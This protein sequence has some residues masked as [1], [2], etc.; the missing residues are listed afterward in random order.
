MGLF[1]AI[2]KLTGN[3]APGLAKASAGA[4]EV[5]LDSLDISTAEGLLIL[6]VPAS[7]V[8]VLKQAA[9]ENSALVL[10]GPA[11]ASRST[12][13]GAPVL[14]AHLTP[15]KSD[16]LPV[17]DQNRGWLVPLTPELRDAIAT[18]LRDEPDGYELTE[19]VAIVV[20]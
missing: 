19:R 2:K 1:D 14:A 3:G 11:D 20:E 16:A 6:T 9:A 7:A 10:R 5:V 17:V 4:P 18:T 15:T 8:S 13:D 12:A